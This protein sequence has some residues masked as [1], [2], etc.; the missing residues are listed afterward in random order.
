MLQVRDEWL[1]A[2]REAVIKKVDGNCVEEDC[3]LQ[4][5]DAPSNDTGKLGYS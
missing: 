3:V 5:G 1:T 4:N 2:F